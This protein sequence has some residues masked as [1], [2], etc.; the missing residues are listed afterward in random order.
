[1]SIYGVGYI[2]VLHRGYID[3]LREVAKKANVFFV[4]GKETLSRFPSLRKDVRALDPYTAVRCVSAL[5]LFRHV[6]VLDS[7]TAYNINL[8]K[9]IVLLPE[10]DISASLAKTL[11]PNTAVFAIPVFLRWDRA[12][13]LAQQ[14]VS[15]DETVE[16]DEFMRQMFCVAEGE[17]QKSSDWWR[18]VGAVLADETGV[19][20]TAHNHHLPSPHAPYFNGDP[21]AEFSQGVHIELSTAIHAEASLIATAAREGIMTKG[22][23]LFVTTFPCPP[24]AK[25]IAEA[26]IAELYFL[27]GYGMLDGLTN[28]RDAG[29]KIIRVT[30][31]DT[32]EGGRAVPYP[33]V[34]L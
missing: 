20:L 23:K 4:L 14:E 9:R 22:T 34:R 6:D 17:L 32:D 11:F 7:L 3:F 29:V 5:H 16:A 31:V 21:R 8:R 30:G 26:G 25:V 28:L 12:S 24:C 1:M 27:G 33:P 2:P 15:A 10:D 18:H 19:L 13:V